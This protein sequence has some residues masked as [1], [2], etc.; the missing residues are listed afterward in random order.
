M[1]ITPYHFFSKHTIVMKDGK[2]LGMVQSVDTDLMV[3]AILSGYDFDNKQDLL[4]LVRVD[5]ICFSKEGLDNDPTC[6]KLYE[7]LL[8]NFR[9]I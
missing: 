3:A 4:E 7:V 9:L 6:K 1:N 8:S 5:E 2:P